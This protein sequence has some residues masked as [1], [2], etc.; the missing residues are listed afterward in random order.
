[1]IRGLQTGFGD[2]IGAPLLA[3]LRGF[4]V[5]LLRLSSEHLSPERVRFLADE[6][7]SAGFVVITIVRTVEQVL[8]LPPGDH[9][10]LMNEPDLNGPDPQAYADLVPVFAE[11]A[12]TA[13]VKLWAGAISNL[14]DRGIQ[15]LDRT[16]PWSWPE[17]V[18]VS[19]HRYPHKDSHL[20]PHPGF[21]SR[22]H[23]I[24]TL[25]AIIGEDRPWGVTEFGYHTGWR[26]KWWFWPVRWTDAQV[27]DMV[28]WEWVFFERMGATGAVLYQLNDG[29]TAT[30]DGRYGCRR[31]PWDLDQWKPVVETFR[32]EP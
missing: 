21:T 23:E 5:G 26:Y 9:V 18:G 32:R 1:M 10:E 25:K 11:A 7:R 20:T 14:N 27:R 15:F 6:A 24:Q 30:A 3:R 17:D 2:P 16:E 29:P 31:W 8:A 22:E 4:H 19:V 12:R 13:G 28:A